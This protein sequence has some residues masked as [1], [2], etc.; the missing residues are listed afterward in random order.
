MA[1]QRHAGQEAGR[2]RHRRHRRQQL[3]VG[4]IDGRDQALAFFEFLKREAPGFSDAY[5]VD[6]PPQ[7]G[8]RE[9][10]RIKGRYQLTADDV[11]SCASFADTIGVN[12]WPIETHVA[13]DVLW[14]WPDIPGSR[15]FNHLPYRMLVRGR[16][17]QPA[18]GRPLRLDDA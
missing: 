4:E 10:R 3:S 16:L 6:I 14:R 1:R 15:G 5:I 18:G 11:L 8:I 17:R 2:P 9:T 7:L 13:G 12:G